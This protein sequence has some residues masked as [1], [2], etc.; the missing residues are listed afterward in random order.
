MQ[1]EVSRVGHKYGISRYPTLKVL[2]ADGEVLGD[3]HWTEVR[4]G[5]SLKEI[6]IEAIDDTRKATKDGKAEEKGWWPF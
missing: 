1:A 6:M 4:G 5:G 2:D 3:V